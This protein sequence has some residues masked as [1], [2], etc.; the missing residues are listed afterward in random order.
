MRFV[1]ETTFAAGKWVGVELDEPQPGKGD[2]EY[3]CPFCG[4]GCC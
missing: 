1:G 2:G 3:V 4:V